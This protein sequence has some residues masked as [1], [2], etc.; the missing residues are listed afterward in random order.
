MRKNVNMDIG[1]II[2]HLEAD[3]CDKLRAYLEAMKKNMAS[4]HELARMIA[5]LENS[6]AE[7][8]LDKLK[9]GFQVVT[10][11]DVEDVLTARKGFPLL[12]SVKESNYLCR[13]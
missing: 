5:D 4:H 2:F 11:E 6:I 12:A 7:R 13:F 9:E 1:G 3:G 10:L 8:F